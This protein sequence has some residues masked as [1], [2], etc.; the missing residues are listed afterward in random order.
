MRPNSKKIAKS[1]HTDGRLVKT[2][3]CRAGGPRVD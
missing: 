3:S 2:L 1:G